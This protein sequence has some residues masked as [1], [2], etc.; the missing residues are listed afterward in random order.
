MIKITD[1]WA[2][3]CGPC[4]QLNPILAE[5]NDLYPDIVLEK[6]DLTTEEGRK[7]AAEKGIKAIPHIEIE[8]DGI[9]VEKFSGF[10]NKAKLIE[11]IEKYV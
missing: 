1:F 5:I 4:R 10:K 6:I 2:Q 8:K 3:W 7:L 11:L 9:L